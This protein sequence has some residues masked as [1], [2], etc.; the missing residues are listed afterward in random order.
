MA[1]DVTE[2]QNEVKHCQSSG[3]IMS[4]QNSFQKGPSFFRAS[5]G[6]ASADLP[7]LQDPLP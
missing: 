4:Y 2:R 7:A 5:G 1:A 6:R 3:P